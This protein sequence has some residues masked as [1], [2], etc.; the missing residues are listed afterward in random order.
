MK[1]L[2]QAAA[3]KVMEEMDV[4]VFLDH[5]FPGEWQKFGDKWNAF[6]HLTRYMTQ[7]Q[8]KKALDDS[9]CRE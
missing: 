2:W 8:F 9:G 1:P 5:E 6:H 7:I 4:E 3:E